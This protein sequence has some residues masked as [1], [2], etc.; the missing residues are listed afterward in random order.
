MAESPLVIPA[1]LPHDKVYTIQVGYKVFQLS[2]L[3][4]SSDGPSY[5]TCYFSQPGYKPLFIDRNPAVFDSIYRHLQGYPV[6]ILG[7]SHFSDLWTDA[8]YFDLSRLQ[9]L[10]KSEAIYAKVGGEPF[11]I[12]RSLLESTSNSPNFFT[13]TFGAYFDHVLEPMVDRGVALRPPVVTCIQLDKRLPSLLRDLLELLRGN[14]LVITSERHREALIAECRY[15]R[16]MELEQRIVPCQIVF[17][18]SGPGEI[19]L[20]LDHLVRR[21]IKLA[22][23]VQYARPYRSEPYRDLIVEITLRD[24]QV[25]LDMKTVEFGGQILQKLSALFSKEPRTGQSETLLFDVLRIGL[26]KVDGEPFSSPDPEPPAVHKKQRI[27]DQVFLSKLLWRFRA[28][29]DEEP[30]TCD[31]L[32]FTGSRNKER[33][34]AFLGQGEAN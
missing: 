28:E 19:V 4:L 3:L 9:A 34:Y 29:T 6:E 30:T 31:L 27:Q 8:C 32:L 12:P 11:R 26:G 16:F 10:F 17:S 20:N 33:K 25:T 21:G 24:F 18:P 15:Y 22:C 1:L 13:V 14:S 7:P 5:F 23:V 2:G